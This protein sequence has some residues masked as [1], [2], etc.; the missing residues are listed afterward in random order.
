MPHSQRRQGTNILNIRAVDENDCSSRDYVELLG[1]KRLPPG[2]AVRVV[3]LIDRRPFTREDTEVA[4]IGEYARGG[5]VYG[6]TARSTNR[7]NGSS[8]YMAS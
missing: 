6:Y 2:A 7:N 8:L 1:G 5:R 3:D 4:C